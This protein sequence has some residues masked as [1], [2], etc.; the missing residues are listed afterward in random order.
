MNL[1]VFKGW[2]LLYEHFPVHYW[3]SAYSDLE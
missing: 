2:L 3:Q 1:W